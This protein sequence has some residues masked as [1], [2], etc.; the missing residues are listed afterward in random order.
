MFALNSYSIM[1][2]SHSEQG[3]V[4]HTQPLGQI[5]LPACF[6]KQNFIGTQLGPCVD[7][8][9]LAVLSYR[10]RVEALQQRPAKLKTLSTLYKT[11]FVT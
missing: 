6:R 8:L 5:W 9:S 10:G 3:L 1:F 11:S 4:N 7:I 2:W